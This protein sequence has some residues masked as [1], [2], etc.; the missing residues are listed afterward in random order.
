[1]K[2]DLG[3]WEKTEFTSQHMGKWKAT[4]GVSKGCNL[5]WLIFENRFEISG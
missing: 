1:M 2:D 4:G 3:P 5:I